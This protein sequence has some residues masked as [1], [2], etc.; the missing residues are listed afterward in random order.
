MS[1]TWRISGRH[2]AR[3][4]AAAANAQGSPMP[5]R[6]PRLEASTA[7][8]AADADG[9]RRTP[10]RLVATSGAKRGSQRRGHAAS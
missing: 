5:R 7:D 9:R 10:L 2:A 4:A 8:L 3:R 6:A 1:A